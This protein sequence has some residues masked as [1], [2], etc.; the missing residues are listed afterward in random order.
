MQGE[1]ERAIEEFLEGSPR[2]SALAEM[3][4]ALAARRETFMR[5]RDSAATEELRKEWEARVSEV[6]KQIRVLR[7]EQTITG[8]VEDSIRATV[9]RN[10]PDMDLDELE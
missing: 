4:A 1:T 9:N 3:V 6:D 10:L 2:A 5:E 7:E 8:F